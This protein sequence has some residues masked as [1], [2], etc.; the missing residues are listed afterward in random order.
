MSETERRT[1][2]DNKRVMIETQRVLDS[3]FDDA[4]LCITGGQ[5]ELLRNLMMYLRREST[6]VSEYHASDYFTP[7]VGEWDNLLAVVANLE[8]KLMGNENVI[9]GYSDPVAQEVKELS[10]SVGSDTLSSA[11]VPSGEVWVV[12]AIAAFDVDTDLS[13]IKIQVFS[14]GVPVHLYYADPG[15]AN[16]PAV[17]SGEV[18][19]PHNGY[20][21]V[22][23][24]GT[25][26][27]DD[28]YLRYLGYKM[29][30]PE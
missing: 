2:Y 11:P 3:Q 4:V 6:F 9:W 16:I 29:K 21:Y 22:T 18:V 24:L 25:V 15:E 7:T 1:R 17:W 19:L 12:Q 5:L 20:I 13:S 10:A 30:V 28:I 26:E 27:G 23:F 14:G 8:E